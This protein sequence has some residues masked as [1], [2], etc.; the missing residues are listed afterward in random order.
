ME[1]KREFQK[2]SQIKKFRFLPIVWV[3]L[4][5][6]FVFF[7]NTY[8]HMD[9]G[10]ENTDLWAVQG[11]PQH[12][13]PQGTGTWH[14]DS[15]WVGATFLRDT[16]KP[17][18]VWLAN[19]YVPQGS[20]HGALYLMVP[21][22]GKPDS[23]LFLFYNKC[24]GTG[25]TR[26]DLS[27]IT[28]TIRDLD[29]LYFMYRSFEQ[30]SGGSACGNYTP[31]TNDLGVYQ[32]DSLFTGPNRA[33]GEGWLNTDKH[34]SRRNGNTLVNPQIPATIFSI[35]QQKLVP[36][37]RRWFEAGW[38]HT[39]LGGDIRTDTVEFGFEDQ[40]NGGDIHF[41]DIRFN[42]TGVFILRGPSQLNLDLFPIKD[43]ISAG[44]TMHFSRSNG[45]FRRMVRKAT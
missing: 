2:N 17:F 6:I 30:N 27:K 45:R 22:P 19:Y 26:V 24:N 11:D 31:L 4:G 40:F 9:L 8:S 38:V 15:L 16:T 32:I 3:S 23:A 42:V 34:Y 7:S 36:V 29:T 33:P 28:P 43:T 41:E 18:V 39:R 21:R 35:N 5:I 12:G 20:Y 1:R 14:A 10:G 13:V 25:P 37:G 44:D